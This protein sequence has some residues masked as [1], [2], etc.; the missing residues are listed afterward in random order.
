MFN[1]KKTTYI[2]SVML[3]LVS[4]L[5]GTFFWMQPTESKTQSYHSGD[6]VSYHTQLVVASADTGNAEL[7]VLEGEKL[8]RASV[9]IKQPSRFSKIYGVTLN[10]EGSRLYAYVATGNTLSKYDISNVYHPILVKSAKDNTRDWFLQ[11]KKTAH[12]IVT[13][14]EKEVKVW[15]YDL[16][17]VNGFKLS[18]NKNS[19]LNVNL[20][21][22]ER[23]L[24]EVQ[25]DFQKDKENDFINIIDT[26]NRQSIS[27]QQ[28]VLNSTNDHSVYYDQ[29]KGFAY[30]AG[31]RVLKQINTVT[32]EVKNFRHISSEGYDVAGISGKNHFYF[33]DGIGI[34]KMDHELNPIDWVYAHKLGISD[35]WTMG[36]KVI[37]HNSKETIVVF[38]HEGI[39]ILNDNL[40]TVAYWQ[41]TDEDQNPLA[42]ITEPLSMS[43]DKNR[44]STNSQVSLRAVGFL[45]N[46][47]VSVIFGKYTMVGVNPTLKKDVELSKVIVTAD[48]NG[49]FNQILTVP[50]I[51]EREKVP[52]PTDI[53]AEGLDSGLRYSIGFIIE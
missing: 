48:A 27:N 32:T 16:Q 41:S 24:F 50:T 53:I 23:F 47:R 8:V 20:S 4:F 46:E 15:N 6:A 17:T 9:I 43:I 33:S 19:S 11:V 2:S 45:P 7:F 10:Q 5:A 51:P 3:I 30:I 49:R 26:T 31:D 18:V 12:H 35:S 14:G 52:Y 42:E 13:I 38:N 1:F 22:D 44:A 25:T 29:A 36:M 39:V 40:D 37:T 21:P 34:V 28:I